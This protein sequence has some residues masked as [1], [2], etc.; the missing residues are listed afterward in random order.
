MF[1]LNINK[2]FFIVIFFYFQIMNEQL[3]EKT[4]S[5]KTTYDNSSINLD[6]QLD[7]EIHSISNSQQSTFHCASDPLNETDHT[8]SND[9]IVLT[10]PTII[11]TKQLCSEI[12]QISTKLWESKETGDEH[13]TFD[14]AIRR[15]LDLKFI[16]LRQLNRKMYQDKQ[17]IKNKTHC[18]K[19]KMDLAH[20]KL[21]DVIFKFEDISL[22]SLD[23]FMKT[24][25]EQYL[26]V[27]SDISDNIDTK[28]R[29]HQLLLAQ[30]RYEHAERI[31]L[32]D[33]YLEKLKKKE[34]ALQRLKEKSNLY[35][36]INKIMSDPF[37]L[38]SHLLFV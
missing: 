37:S 18:A 15:H 26:P 12:K 9:D 38:I 33:D 27:L 31:R 17:C 13:W 24:A 19:V 21:Q 3:I 4:F 36:E 35:R 34:D 20:M 14:T 29:D 23:E 28:Q 2:L 7:P 10:L 11:E 30:L 22:I 1:D 32:N 5:E 6:S 8:S 16:K 25:P